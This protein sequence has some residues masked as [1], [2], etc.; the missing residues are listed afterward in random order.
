MAV[1]KNKRKAS[2][3]EV[4]HHAF[5]LR[6]EITDLLLRDFG[7]KARPKKPSMKAR[8]E[9]QAEAELKSEARRVA[10]S[11]W[12]IGQEQEAVLNILRS[13]IQNI[14]RANSIYPS[15][16]LPDDIYEAEVKERRL[17]QDRAVAECFVLLQELQYIIETLPVD[18]NKYTRFAD[19]IQLEI[20]LI[21]GWRKADKSRYG[22]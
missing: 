16:E 7:Y 22:I 4:F 19:S 15:R 1:L 5:E 11:D 6:K 2:Q 18:I 20:A 17:Y 8:T 12:Y 10:F 13:L 3:F 14:I 9:Q 21:K